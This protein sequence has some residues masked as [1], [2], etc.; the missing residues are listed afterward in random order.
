MLKGKTAVVT[1]A[2]RG[3]GRAIALKLAEQGANI[4]VNYVSSEQ[5]GLK[6]AQEIENLGG[7]ALVLKADVS[8][9]S[10]AEQ[11]IAMAKAEFGTIDILINNAGITRDGLLMRMSEDDFDRVVEVDLKGVFNCTRHA[12]PIMVKQR[13]GRIINITSVVGILGNAGQVNY[14]AAKAGVI[15]LTKSLAKEI[16]SRNITVNA[17]AP[18]FI[19][20]DMTSGLSDK[21]K[22]LTKESIALKRFGKPENIADTILFLASDAGE[23]I[24]GQVISVDGGMAF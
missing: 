7:R 4:A 21:V 3:I 22:E 23:Y 24:T 12:V 19:E 15:G 6:L 2:S 18:G 9:F 11:L 16:G 5:D 13:S 8:V 10:E 1:G 14:A 20:T 17:V